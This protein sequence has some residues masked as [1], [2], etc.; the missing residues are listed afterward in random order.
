[1]GKRSNLTSTL[2]KE[3]RNKRK[4]V[5]HRRKM[6]QKKQPILAANQLKNT[7]F[8]CDHKGSVFRFF[9]KEEDANTLAQGDVYLSTLERCRSY[10]NAEQGDSEEAYE[11][12]NSGHAV[13]RGD[14]PE[15]IRR[16]QQ[17]G[18]YISPN[19]G[20]VTISNNTRITSLPDAYVL[21]TTTEFSPENINEE[22]G[23]F[24]VEIKNPREF[25]NVISRKI[26][27]MFAI[28]EAGAGKIKYADRNYTGLDQPPGP[29]GFVKPSIPYKKQKEFRFLWLMENMDNLEPLLIKCPEISNL[30]TRIA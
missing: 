19:I 18:I 21:C 25:F 28:R 11:T 23:K 12:Y 4:Q 24:C 30:C 29:I 9:K 26:D 10:E 3:R 16:A 15:I 6:E 8:L 14:D 22:I 5:E 13:G 20:R 2:K 17:S 27:S 7:F 1:M